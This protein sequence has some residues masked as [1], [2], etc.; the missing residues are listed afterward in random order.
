[1]LNIWVLE[2]SI[3]EEQQA[4][5]IHRSRTDDPR[6]TRRGSSRSGSRDRAERAIPGTRHSNAPLERAT[7]TSDAWARARVQLTRALAWQRELDVGEVDSRAALARREGL[8]RARVTQVMKLLDLVPEVQAVVLGDR[9]AE[10]ALSVRELRDLALVE[11]EGQANELEARL[12]QARDEALVARACDLGR[13]LGFQHLFARARRWQG[14]LDAGEFGSVRELAQVEGLSPG[15]VSDVL[16][17]L[18]LAPEIAAVLDVPAEQAPEG[19]PWRDVMRVA[20]VRG[21]E[22]QIAAADWVQS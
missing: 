7:A 12:V 14:L 19:V 18:C 1:M 3:P 15:R 13:P 8:S 16:N 2:R 6:P 20:R 9:G 11:P 10:V 22:G 17:L 5:R 4:Q 21:W